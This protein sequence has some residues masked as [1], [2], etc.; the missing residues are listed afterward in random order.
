MWLRMSEVKYRLVLTI[1]FKLYVFHN[2]WYRFSSV[3]KLSLGVWLRQHEKH[4][5]FSFAIINSELIK[6]LGSQRH[7][8]QRNFFRRNFDPDFVLKL[9]WHFLSTSNRFRVFV[10][11]NSFPSNPIWNKG[12]FQDPALRECLVRFERASDKQ[13]EYWWRFPF[14]FF[15]HTVTTKVI[16]FWLAIVFWRVSS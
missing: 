8:L 10:L 13:E 16:S 4:W 2:N 3:I 14:E 15:W 12:K 6:L 7:F 9:W 5:Q 1:C 11:K